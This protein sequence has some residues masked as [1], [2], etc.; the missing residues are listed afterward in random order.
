MTARFDYQD[1]R[2]DI[3]SH[4]VKIV[5]RDKWY[6]LK[7][8]RRKEY[9]ERFKGLKW[10]EVHLK[11][12]N[13]VLYVS[14]VFETRYIPYIPKGAQ[15]LDVNLRHVV[16]YDGSSVRRYRTRFTDAL[17]RKARAEELQK[18]YSKRWRYNKRILNKIRSLHRKARNITIDWCRKFAKEVVL[19]AKR[20][21]HAVILENLRYLH[22]KAVKNGSNIAW[23][24]SLFAY[25][26]L[27]ESVVAKA[28]EYNVPI[29]FVDPKD[30]SST[31]PRCGAKLSYTHRLAVCRICRFIAD[32]DRVGAMNIWLRALHAYTG[33]PGSP[34]STPAMN[35]EARGSRGT[36][37]EGMK[38]VIRSIQK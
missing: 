27:Q 34:Q 22:V 20:H 17:G 11:Y 35:N 19:K 9:I 10:K 33:E 4:I 29:L 16:V 31:C 14:I 24:L 12:Y 15:A 25:R 6:T 37:N 30:T 18:E 32:R 13:G 36:R 7:L 5:L 26:K 2:V 1:A 8:M 21:S 23:K 38:K 28:I 3:D